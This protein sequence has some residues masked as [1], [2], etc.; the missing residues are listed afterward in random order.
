M[1]VYAGEKEDQSFNLTMNDFM[2]GT[3]DKELESASEPQEA[4]KEAEI[5]EPEVSPSEP[6]KEAE[7]SSTEEEE[8]KPSVSDDPLENL[9]DELISDKKAEVDETPNEILQIKNTEKALET[10]EAQI[11]N[12]EQVLKAASPL[13]NPDGSKLE[14]YKM[15]DGKSLY[16]LTRDELNSVVVQLQ[17]S[18]NPVLA[19]D[20]KKAFDQFKSNEKQIGNLEQYYETQV[21]ELAVAKETLDWN[22]AEVR[23]KDSF[24]KKGIDLTQE[25][26]QTITQYLEEKHKTD[27]A[28]SYRPKDTQIFEALKATGITEKIRKATNQ[29][30]SVNAPD[31]G[32]VQKTV[33]SSD[34]KGLPKGYDFSESQIKAMS[35]DEFSKIEAQLER[36]MIQGRV[37]QDL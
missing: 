15:E 6:K 34:T 3:E 2:E 1:N 10:S 27:P 11:R 30:E 32:K 23:W 25:H 8:I 7:P 14:D 5:T 12:L 20:I 19:D 28:Y 18:G 22:K 37:L 24:K 4:G 9:I 26:I 33:K 29:V 13:V 16:N 31:A 35:A 36:A 17:D 21:G